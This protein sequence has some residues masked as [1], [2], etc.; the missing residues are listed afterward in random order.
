MEELKEEIAGTQISV[1]CPDNKV[2]NS[3]IQPENRLEGLNNFKEFYIHQIYKKVLEFT[4]KREYVI[5]ESSNNED[6]NSQKL[7]NF[8]KESSIQVGQAI[9]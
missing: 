6:G 5:H 2:S 4:F 7:L 8:N 9:I 3:Q 1:V